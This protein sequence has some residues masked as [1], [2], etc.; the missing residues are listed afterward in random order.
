MSPQPPSISTVEDMEGWRLRRDAAIRHYHELGLCPIPLRGKIP[1]H[2]GWNKPEKYQGVDVEEVLRM[3]APNDNVGLLAGIP[4]KDGQYLRIIDYDDSELWNRHITL[5]EAGKG[6]AWLE[7]SGTVHTGSGGRHHYV[8]SD[9]PGKFVFQGH[10][11]NPHGGEVQGT[12]TQCVAP[13]SIHPETKEEYQWLYENWDQLPVVLDSQL[14]YS[15]KPK[16]EKTQFTGGKKEE[17][18]PLFKAI[19]SPLFTESKKVY[20]DYSTID[21]IALFRARGEV[22]QDNGD[23]VYVLCPNRAQHTKNTDGTSSTVILRTDKGGQRFK[24]LHGHCE[25]LSDRDELIKFLGGEDILQGYA[26]KIMQADTDFD[27]RYKAQV[28]SEG[29]P[30]VEEM[31]EVARKQETK[32]KGVVPP[33]LVLDPPGQL[34]DLVRWMNVSTSSPIPIL[35]VGASLAFAAG[36]LGHSYQGLSGARPQI[37][38]VGLAE[39]GTGKEHARTVLRNIADAAGIGNRFLDGEMSGSRALEIAMENRQGRLVWLVDEFGQAMKPILSGGNSGSS[40]QQSLA[41]TIM[42][43]DGLINSTYD[44]QH[45]A[46]GQPGKGKGKHS[47]SIK[48]PVLSIYGTTV[49]KN[50]IGILKAEHLSDGYINRFLHVRSWEPAPVHRPLNGT[51]MATSP[52][53]ELVQ[54]AKRW[55]ELSLEDGLQAGQVPFTAEDAS[56]SPRVARS[57]M[58]DGDAE[59]IYMQ[60]EEEIADWKE[61]LNKDR[62]GS[63]DLLGRSA[64]KVRKVAMIV[65]AADERSTVDGEIMRYAVELVRYS[66]KVVE[67]MLPM[68]SD[69]NPERGS[70]LNDIVNYI[71]KQRKKGRTK[72]EL[73]NRFRGIDRARMKEY[74]ETLIEGGEIVHAI[75]GE[76]VSK[77]SRFIGARWASPPATN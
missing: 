42:K 62:E 6:Y 75:E 31:R 12:G 11:G 9:T 22:I 77:T 38:V 41:R 46:D 35:H 63:G 74:L 51:F 57:M 1:Y 64:W 15:Y 70:H 32:E 54:L 10:N 53:E 2:T 3:F 43:M 21:F 68:I 30:S 60:F 72:S 18:G 20:Y 25:H 27:R 28:E 4:L 17:D 67:A 55:E 65:A 26:Q 24:C 76:G 52:P 16:T 40:F 69:N 33:P 49:P 73:T 44:G 45:Y 36:L 39:T 34:G 7:N 66:E 50:Y 56:F 5:T 14:Q 13:P 58:G 47:V 61:S 19:A 48:F 59:K 23:S 37:Y 8:L 71:S 29:K